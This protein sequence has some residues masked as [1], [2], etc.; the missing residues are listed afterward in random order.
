[1]SCFRRCHAESGQ[2]FQ[3]DF[4]VSLLFG[5]FFFE[6]FSQARVE[7]LLP[8]TSPAV[9]SVL[10]RAM[11]GQELSR[12]PCEPQDAELRMQPP[13]SSRRGSAGRV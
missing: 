8:Q 5:N 10:E 6:V 11:A 9:A 4:V 13:A 2:V 3:E 1:L 7:R 12:A